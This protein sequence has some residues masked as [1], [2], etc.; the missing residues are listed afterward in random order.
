MLGIILAIV[1]SAS[2]GASAVVARLGLLDMHPVAA[3]WLSLITGCILLTP[4][5]LFQY[6][7]DIA[8]LNWSSYAWCALM[9][10]LNFP[11]GRLLNY[12]SVRMAGVTRATP[13]LAIAPLFSVTIAIIFLGEQAT[14]WL[15]AGTAAIVAGVI[16]IVTDTSKTSS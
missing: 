11:L 13:I 10:F 5:V 7:G 12:T 14:G 6:S 2:W 16:L 8:N 9:G 1:A 4:I 15:L 3:T